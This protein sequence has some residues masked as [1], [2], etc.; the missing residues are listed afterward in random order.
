MQLNSFAPI[1]ISGA[2]WSFRN[3]GY[4]PV[5]SDILQMTPS[6]VKVA[7]FPVPRKPNGG[8]PVASGIIVANRGAADGNDCWQYVRKRS[9]KL[10]HS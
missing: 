2:A 5:L 9:R 7:V 4:C 10:R 3:F 6:T 8:V 1:R